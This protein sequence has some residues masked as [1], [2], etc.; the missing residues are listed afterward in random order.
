MNTKKKIYHNIIMVYYYIQII[1]CYIFGN[2][3]KK[4]VNIIEN[5]KVNDSDYLL[6]PINN[7]ENNNVNSDFFFDEY[8]PDKQE[9]IWF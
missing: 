3:S 2:T 6:D 1:Y 4:S 7:I 9:P 5:N 8:I